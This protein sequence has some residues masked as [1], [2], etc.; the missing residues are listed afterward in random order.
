MYISF[1]NDLLF[2]FVF[3]SDLMRFWIICCL[4]DVEFMIV[5]RL[6]VELCFWWWKSHIVGGLIERSALFVIQTCFWIF[7]SVLDYALLFYRILYFNTKTEFQVTGLI[8]NQILIL[9]DCRSFGGKFFS[10]FFW[11]WGWSG[12]GVGGLFQ[13]FQLWLQMFRFLIK[14]WKSKISKL[15]YLSIPFGF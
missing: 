4:Q 11:W 2:G 5:L 3:L 13:S 8:W 1:L 15:W 14:S 12:S 7:F 9:Y 6:R 10:F